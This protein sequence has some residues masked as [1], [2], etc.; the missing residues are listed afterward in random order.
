VP[1]W[2]TW[3]EATSG[4]LYEEGGFFR[5]GTG[6]AAHFRTSVHASPLFADAVLRLVDETDAALGQPETLDIVDVGAGRGELLL[7]LRDRAGPRL[8]ARLRLHA[9]EL[10]DRPA[11]LPEEIGWTPEIPKQINGLLIANEWL[12]NVP[13]D[14][15]EHTGDGVRLVLVN[16]ET[17]DERPGARLSLEDQQW[18]DAWWPLDVGEIGDRAEIGRPRDQ[19]WASAVG[20]VEAGLAVAIDYMH[21]LANRAMGLLPSGTLTGYR[22][23]RAVIPR[24]DGT[25]DVTSHVALDACAIAGEAAGAS[26]TTIMSQREALQALG[27]TAPRPDAAL[28][29]TNPAAY[30]ASLDAVSQTAELTARGGFG[31][32]GWLVQAVAMPLPASLAP[33]ASVS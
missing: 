26:A 29:R 3:R 21:T 18:L 1:T 7:A 2:L 22:D 23:G 4:A 8:R 11:H 12:D 5:N 28:A 14:V 27:I 16:P 25:C 24:P 19:A 30:L 10:A 33:P 15:A 9:V 20:C 17:G 31:D 32:F 13:V 6:P